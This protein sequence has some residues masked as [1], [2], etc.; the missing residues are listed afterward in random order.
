[1]I[2]N[3][4][5]VVASSE[6]NLHFRKGRGFTTKICS[7]SVCE[8]NVMKLGDIETAEKYRV[9]AVVYGVFL[10]SQPA[11]DVVRN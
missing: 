2:C 8:L 6:D 5:C 11:Y 1:M 3:A 10:V 7:V 4:Q 9:C